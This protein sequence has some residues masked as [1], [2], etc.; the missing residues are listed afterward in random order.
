M[1]EPYLNLPYFYYESALYQ[2]ES[3]L[4]DTRWKSKV[5]LNNVK[6]KVKFISIYGFTIFK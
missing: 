3:I 1:D 5:S 4:N 6:S 2:I